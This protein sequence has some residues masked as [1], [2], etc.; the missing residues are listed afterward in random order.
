[1]CRTIG[2]IVRDLKLTGYVI[3]L[4]L[5][6]NRTDVINKLDNLFSDCLRDNSAV[7]SGCK[8]VSS[9]VN[10][11]ASNVVLKSSCLKLLSS[12]VVYL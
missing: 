9:L 2:G 1:M 6:E 10:D 11:S 5:F 7:V 3:L 12:L 4:G 8:L